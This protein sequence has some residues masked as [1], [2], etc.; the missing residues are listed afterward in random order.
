V[1]VIVVAT[2]CHVPPVD[3]RGQKVR[4]LMVFASENDR[5]TRKMGTPCGQGVCHGD[6]VELGMLAEVVV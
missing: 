2:G 5:T 3:Q 6:D 1:A 4:Q